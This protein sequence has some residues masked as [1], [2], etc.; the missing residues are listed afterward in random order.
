MTYNVDQAIVNCTALLWSGMQEVLKV[1]VAKRLT[2]KWT[3]H[4]RHWSL[5]SSSLPS[6]APTPPRNAARVCSDHRNNN[7]SDSNHTDRLYAKIA[8]KLLLFTAYW[9][10]ASNFSHP[11]RV[12]FAR[13][14]V[15]RL[16][17]A[18]IDLNA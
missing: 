14:L 18:S 11:H 10:V 2:H 12:E 9:S 5:S 15:E 7:N 13:A 1:Q 3:K 6:P 8:H 16:R 4:P 17:F